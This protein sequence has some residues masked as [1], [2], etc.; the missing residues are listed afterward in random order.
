MIKAG[1]RDGYI[2]GEKEYRADREEKYRRSKEQ[3]GL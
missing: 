2:E 1:L 3:E